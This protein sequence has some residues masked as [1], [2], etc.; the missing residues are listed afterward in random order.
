MKALGIVVGIVVIL[1]VAAWLALRGP[2]IP[3]DT[4]EAKYN[5]RVVALR[6]PAGRFSRALPG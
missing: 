3:Y 1:V 4:L 2:D 5:R 6:R